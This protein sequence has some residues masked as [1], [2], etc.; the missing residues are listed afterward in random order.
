[1]PAFPISP[2]SHAPREERGDYLELLALRDPLLGSSEQDYI[3]ITQRDGEDESEDAQTYG[4]VSNDRTSENAAEEAISELEERGLEF[5][6]CNKYYPYSLKNDL[7][8][9]KKKWGGQSYQF[10][11]WF[12]LLTSRLDMR[13]EKKQA[14]LDGT[15]LFEE[16]CLH[17]AIRYLGGPDKIRVGSML[18]GTARQTLNWENTEGCTRSAFAQN[19]SALC[20]SLGEGG[21]FKP[22]RVGARIRPKDAKVD[23]VVWRKFFDNHPGKLIAFGQCKTG[24]HW[25]DGLSE[26]DP[27]SFSKKFITESFAVTPIKLFFTA[28]R[29]STDRYDHASDGG[30]FFDRCRIIQ[31]ADKIPDDLLKRCQSWTKAAGA[32]KGLDL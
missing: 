31:H 15:Q 19:V 25:S 28:A 21:D 30:V 2:T 3:E 11:Y 5:G 6:H 10:L 26:L 8:I 7:L 4:G 29:V 16:I 20:K 12:L 22:K 32:S 14:R 23:V 13:L 9:L 17:A 1:M 24:R 27:Y 18:F